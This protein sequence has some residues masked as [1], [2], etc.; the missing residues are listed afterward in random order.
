[1]RDQPVQGGSDPRVFRIKENGNNRTIKTKS[2]KQ[3]KNPES[4]N[5]QP[6][7]TK[8]TNQTKKTHKK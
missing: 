3:T 4:K 5:K 6:N 2:N 7:Q 1:M 8:P